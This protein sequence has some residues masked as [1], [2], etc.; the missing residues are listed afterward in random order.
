M[1]LIWSLKQS[2]ILAI[3]VMGWAEY[4]SAHEISR[5]HDARRTLLRY[6]S[7][8]GRW[9][10]RA[11][12]Y[13][14]GFAKIRDNKRPHIPYCYYHGFLSLVPEARIIGTSNKEITTQQHSYTKRCLVKE[15]KNRWTNSQSSQMDTRQWLSLLVT[16]TAKNRP[17]ITNMQ[18]GHC[19]YPCL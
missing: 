8:R 5:R 10:S 16:R 11:R 12:V 17:S 19:R 13:F 9:F 4:T 2:L 3:T 6:V 14:A 15:A 18:G 1:L 7:P